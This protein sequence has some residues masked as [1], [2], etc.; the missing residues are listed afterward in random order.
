[1][2]AVCDCARAQLYLKV[3]AETSL[4]AGAAEANMRARSLVPRPK[5]VIESL[6]TR[7][8]RA[9]ALALVHYSYYVFV[10]METQ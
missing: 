10:S 7:L 4:G 8:A 6:G 5:T 2:H 3:G 1:M 9:G